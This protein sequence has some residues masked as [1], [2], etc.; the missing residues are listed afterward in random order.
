M[1]TEI[2]RKKGDTSR[3][4]VTLIDDNGSINLT[5]CTVVF[6]MTST[7]GTI[8]VNQQS[9][10]VLDQSVTANRGIVTYSFTSGQVNATGKYY[11]EFKVT[12]QN[13]EILTVP[14]AP[15]PYVIIHIKDTLV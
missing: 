14:S 2:Y 5:G 3:L 6:T 10:V 9:C 8:K 1:A 11:G 15:D 12:L 4:K 7:A 13:G